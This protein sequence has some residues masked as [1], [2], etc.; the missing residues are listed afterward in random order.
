MPKHTDTQKEASPEM[1]DFDVKEQQTREKEIKVIREKYLNPKNG[2]TA[3]IRSSYSKYEVRVYEYD[4]EKTQWKFKEVDVRES[5]DEVLGDITDDESDKSNTNKS[6]KNE[7][8]FEEEDEDTDGG[9]PETTY[10]TLQMVLKNLKK[11]MY[12]LA[13]DQI[14]EFIAV[15]GEKGKPAPK[16]RKRS[17]KNVFMSKAMTKLK[18]LKVERRQRMPR[19]NRFYGLYKK[20]IDEIGKTL[21]DVDDLDIEMFDLDSVIED[22]AKEK[23][24]IETNEN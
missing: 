8:E 21:T 24:E 13:I 16:K 2:E 22:V 18:E 4:E 11:K 23:D 10:V 19:A 14:T 5:D 6:D 20:Q 12:E 1:E 9:K 7:L 3:K 15:Y 17:L